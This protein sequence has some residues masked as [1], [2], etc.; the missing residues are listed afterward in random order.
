MSAPRRAVGTYIVAALVLVVATLV[1]R[2]AAIA[3][4]GPINP[5]EAELMMQARAA[6][7][8]PVP[9]STW[10]M[11]TT[12]PVWVLT[13]AVFGALGA[14]LTLAFAHALSAIL[15]ALSA[16][17]LFV[18]ARRVLGDWAAML[19]TVAWWLPIAVVFPAGG[20]TNIS[21]LSTEY[22]PVALLLLSALIPRE[23]LAAHPAL[24]IVVGVLAGLAVAAK[25]QIAPLAVVLPVVQ[26]LLTRP[27]W[28]RVLVSAIWWMLG[29]IVPVGILVLIV[30]LS[31]AV[32]PVLLEQ[33][34]TFLGSYAGG[35]TWP[36]RIANTITILR[37]AAPYLLVL[38]VGLVWLGFRSEWRVNVA[39]GALVAAGL[40]AV[41][42]GGQAFGHYLI[43]LFGAAALA[44]ELPI[45]EGRPAIPGRRLRIALTAVLAVA[46]V[47]LLVVGGATARWRPAQPAQIA[48][49]FSPDSVLRNDALAG[50]CPSGTPAVVW[51]WAPELYL[52][53][54]WTV[55]SP[56]P[57]TLGLTANPQNRES[58][59]PLVRASLDR[60]DCV[61]DAVG[62]PFFGVPAA[63]SIRTVYPALARVLDAD[64]RVAEGVIDCDECTVYV[65]G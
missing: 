61:V 47:A 38:T 39:R 9:F 33:T 27:D 21:A 42:A 22:L 50:V 23:R 5:D 25:Y 62:A 30:A 8:S 64:F 29:A 7:L 14:P 4:W 16:F 46:S 52:A 54:D 45:A 55:Q 37:A 28:R 11:G 58:A 6:T 56:Y 63:G 32:S 59:E 53:Q 18:A 3:E 15:L 13:L 49:A 20:P 41:V 40:V 44:L 2:G 65:R 24:F 12:G 10:T 36:G 34:F 19:A 43:I 51:G 31:P 57:N 1:L 35:V 17:A 26:V 48:A 60:S